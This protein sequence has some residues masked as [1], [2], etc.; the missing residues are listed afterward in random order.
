ML[1]LAG[2]SKWVMNINRFAKVNWPILILPLFICNM[3][4][5]NAAIIGASNDS[6]LQRIIP[7]P[8]SVVDDKPG[9]ENTYQQGFNEVQNFTLPR[10][11]SVNSGS[12]IPAGTVVNSHMIFLNTNG[13]RRVDDINVEWVFDGKILGVQH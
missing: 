10:D 6:T 2:G 3:A 11:I 8:P 5:S 4:A 1:L 9:A 7:A 13:T 12:Y